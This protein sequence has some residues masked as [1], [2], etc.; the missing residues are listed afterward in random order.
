[1]HVNVLFEALKGLAAMAEAT[2]KVDEHESE[3]KQG[4]V[5]L[6]LAR[7]QKMCGCVLALLKMK[8]KTDSL[9][10]DRVD[11]L[12]EEIKEGRKHGLQED[13]VLPP[14]VYASTMKAISGR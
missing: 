2:G 11:K 3:T 9:K 12:K 13:K 6:E 4:R 14:C 10:K 8:P 5:V 1:M 7:S